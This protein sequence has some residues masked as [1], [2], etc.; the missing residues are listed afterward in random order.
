MTA[1]NPRFI[2]RR[3]PV[4]R[5]VIDFPIVALL[6]SVLV[7]A[8]VFGGLAYLVTLLDLPL[9]EGGK[10]VFNAAL[11]SALAIAI[12]KLVVPHVGTERRDY[13]PLAG[14]ASVC[15]LMIGIVGAAVLMTAIVGLIALMGGYTVSGMGTAQSWLEIVFVAGIQAAV[16]EEIAFRGIL[17]RYLEDLGGSWFALAATSALFGFAHIANDNATWFS[18]L[19]IA[20]EA[21]VML[22]GAYMLSRSLWLP[23]GLHFGWN[24]TQG[25]VWDVP[26]SGHAVDGMVEAHPAGAALISGGAFGAEAS[27]VALVLAGAVGVWL[28]VKAVRA[29]HVVRPW[30]VR[31]RMAREIVRA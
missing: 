30:W 12:Y 6:L 14:I 7:F 3:F 20:V 28:T 11:G 4:W 2:P 9:S 15:W 27:V 22:G 29:G 16:I 21:G 5:Q 26:V 10:M 1:F 19:A 8:I 31:R 24:V 23:I 25:L 18:S 13:L 17:F